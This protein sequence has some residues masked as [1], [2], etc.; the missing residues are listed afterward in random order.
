MSTDDRS[1]N[2]LGDAA[3]LALSAELVQE[4]RAVVQERD[5]VVDLLETAEQGRDKVKPEIFAKVSS[6]YRAK[7]KKIASQYAPLR[8]RIVQEL[9]SIRSREREIRSQLGGI[10]DQLDELRFRC[11]VGEFD[12]GELE[13]REAERKGT[14]EAFE[15]SLST[16]EATY[17]TARELLGDDFEA[18]ISGD[19]AAPAPAAASAPPVPATPRE[20]AAAAPEPTGEVAAEAPPAPPAPSVAEPQEEEEEE[21]EEPESGEPA[22]A[23]PP[24][25]AAGD[26]PVPEGTVALEPGPPPPVK[27]TGSADTR[28]LTQG[29]LTRKKPDGGKTFVIDSDGLVLG[30]ST[31]CDVLIQGATVSRRHAVISWEEDGY[32]IEDVSSGGGISVN[33][34]RHQRVQLKSGDQVEIGAAH[35]EYEG[36]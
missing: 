20:P 31:S 4:T 29:L 2:Q 28:A 6:D 26:G 17:E 10:R 16:I 3:S 24:V 19:G 27:T 15:G 1:E 32:W 33:G 35:F 11:E 22:A 25:P 12:R 34:E 36:P 9:G 30:R 21:E 23:P 13:A 7:L 8:D 14:I 18:A 5:R